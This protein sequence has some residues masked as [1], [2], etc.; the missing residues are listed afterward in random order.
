[1]LVKKEFFYP[2][3]LSIPS[4]EAL[5]KIQKMRMKF[6]PPV[7]DLS[8]DRNF[9][10]EK[11]AVS[12][13]LNVS[14]LKRTAASSHKITT[15]VSISDT[16][17]GN[18]ED[19]ATEKQNE[20]RQEEEDSEDDAFESES[21]SDLDDFNDA[22]DRNGIDKNA[23]EKNIPNQISSNPVQPQADV[24]LKMNHFLGD[25][26]S[27]NPAKLPS[28]VSNIPNLEIPSF[29]T[30]PSL[31]LA[32]IGGTSKQH[33]ESEDSRPLNFHQE[34]FSSSN[35]AP[36]TFTVSG[37]PE[38]LHVRFKNTKPSKKI[39][40]S[41]YQSLTES[42]DLSGLSLKVQLFS[43]FYVHLNFSFIEDKRTDKKL[44]LYKILRE[45]PAQNWPSNRY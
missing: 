37:I 9:L 24:S 13:N 21:G 26:L 45:P 43:V 28:P 29:N 5:E 10:V 12:E 35:L 41:G 20:R 42:I 19:Q 17:I 14:T 3:E 30:F 22:D 33:L 2:E 34:K 11:N 40:S 27:P 1:M 6:S 44:K 25:L 39:V 18:E 31:S 15:P 38:S 23:D 16:I 32:S 7:P 4:K 36:S 8:S